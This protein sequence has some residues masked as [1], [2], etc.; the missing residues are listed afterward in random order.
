MSGVGGDRAPRVRVC[1]DGPV[2]VTGDVV[3]EADDGT[4]HPSTRPVSAAMMPE[5]PRIRSASGTASSPVSSASRPSTMARSAPASRLPERMAAESGPATS[6]R[7]G[8]APETA[9]STVSRHH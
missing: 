3:V 4:L 8:G 7:R 9:S 5:M 1:P 6:C 2:L